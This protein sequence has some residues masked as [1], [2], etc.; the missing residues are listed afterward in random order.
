VG[1]YLVSTNWS[2]SSAV[3][4]E[5]LANVV[6]SYKNY[7]A[8]M[9][10]WDNTCHIAALAISAMEKISITKIRTALKRDGYPLNKIVRL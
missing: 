9:L 1:V 3:P 7:E 4:R 5:S 10:S 6:W 2:R 8:I